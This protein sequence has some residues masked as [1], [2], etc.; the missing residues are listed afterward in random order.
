MSL[1]VMPDVKPMDFSKVEL[2]RMVVEPDEEEINKALVRVA[3][4]HKTSEPI[5]SSRKSKVGDVVIIDF[6]GKVDGVEFHGGKAEDYSL[7]LGSDSF[8]PGFEDQLSGA[9]VGDNVE[10]K[11]KFPD[12]YASVDLAGKEALFNVKVKELRKAIPAVIDDEL[13]KK[14]GAEDLNSLKISFREEH[15]REFI[16]LARM[17]MKRSLM[18][19]LEK[20]HDFE[21][22][23]TMVD[24]EF[25]GIWE[26]F[27]QGNE[28]RV[29]QMNQ[30]KNQHDHYCNNQFQH[31]PNNWRLLRCQLH[32]KTQSH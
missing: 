3:N 14:V 31:K 28:S 13:A 4:A 8:I 20:N 11:V 15:E 32:H 27:D 22:P 17:R 25:D 29:Q 21:V 1:E 19:Q 18:D 30:Q 9:M 12:E 24:R 2:E 6:V 5:T 16:K 10:V 26:Q 23:Q 7:E